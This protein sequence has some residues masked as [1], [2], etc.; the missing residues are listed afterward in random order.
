MEQKE[1]FSH[2]DHTNL[3][4]CALPSDIMKTVDEGIKYGC[5]SV[6][7]PPCYV[8]DAARHSDGRV[9]ICTVAGFPHGNVPPQAKAYEAALAAGSGADEIDMVINIGMMKAGYTKYVADEITLV[10]AAA[11]NRILKVIIEACRLSDKEKAELCR[12]VGAAGADYIKTSTGFSSGGATLADVALLK[13][14]APAGLLVKA[15]GGIRTVRDCESFI[16][17]GADRIGAS[18]IVR[19]FAAA[20]NM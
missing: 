9:R 14:Y 15:A 17:A 13:R 12:I 4:P 16:A 7:I 5:A 1:L 3:S 11:Q 8:R 18:A 2:I 20:E 6:C 19:C 10:R